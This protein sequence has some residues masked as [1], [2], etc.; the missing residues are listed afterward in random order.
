M[1]PT[2]VSQSIE[3]EEPL[4]IVLAAYLWCPLWA[5]KRLNFLSDN[6]SVVEI[7]RSGTSRTPTIKSLV[8]YLSLLAARHSFSFTASPVRGKSNLIADSLSHIQRFHQ[9]APDADSILTQIP[10]PLLSDLEFCCQ[11]NVTYT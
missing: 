1:A 10:Q 5:S 9:L 3:Y 8:R 4:P 7:L 11:I 6:H 2:Q